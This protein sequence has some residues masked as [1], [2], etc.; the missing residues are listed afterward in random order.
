MAC[1]DVGA[2]R[3]CPDDAARGAR[4]T[5]MEIYGLVM[6]FVLMA[7]AGMGAWWIKRH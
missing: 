5:S 3:H 6:P 2:T 4:M 7:V 1:C